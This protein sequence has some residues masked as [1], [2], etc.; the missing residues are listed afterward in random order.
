MNSGRNSGPYATFLV[1]HFEVG[2]DTKSLEFQ[3]R[4]WAVVIDFIRLAEKY[5]ARLTLQFNPQWAEYILLD[6]ERHELLKRWRQ[7]GHEIGLHH[8]GYDHGN[9]NGYTNRAGKEKDIRYR[10][11]TGDMME[12]MGRLVCPGKLL[13]G[14]ISDEEIDYP[15]C[16]KYDTE[17]VR[18][19]HAGRKPVK[20]T[21]SDRQVIQ[22]GMACM[23]YDGDIESFRDEYRKS[24][25]GDVFGVITHESD[26]ARNTARFEEWF[27]FVRSNKQ[28]IRTVS[29]IAADYL[30]AF[31]VGESDDPLTFSKDVQPD[32]ARFR[33]YLDGILKRFDSFRYG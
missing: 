12:V 14:T 13:S 7:A 21:L 1:V 22:F 24:G 18:I 15:E 30:A 9:W 27:E 16:I 26:L 32:S 23:S 33:K 6:E 5:G 10:G 4:Y 17:G 28:S 8:H 31:N 3:N 29:E 19:G 25:R 11:N 20:V 2:E